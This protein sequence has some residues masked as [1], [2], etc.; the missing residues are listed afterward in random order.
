VKVYS[1]EQIRNVALLS[2]SGAGKTS[3][4]EAMLFD[5][6]AITRLGKVEEGTTTSDYDPDEVKRKISLSIGLVPC[7]YHETKLNLLDTPGYADFVGEVVAAL[8]VTD[9]ALL[10]VCGAS[11]VEVGTEQNWRRARERS[12]PTAVLVNKLDRENADF[13]RVLDQVRNRISPHAVAVQLPIGREHGFTGVVDLLSGK[14]YIT[15]DGTT[16]EAAPPPSWPIRSPPSAS[17]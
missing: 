16:T 14:A 5:S 7:E 17:V 12:L 4:A 11:G 8:A 10:V 2:H 9:S 15:K 13:L 1:S 6:G 3:L